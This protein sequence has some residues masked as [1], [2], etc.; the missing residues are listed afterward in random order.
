MWVL[1]TPGGPSR[2][3][4]ALASTKDRVARSL[5]LRGSRSGFLQIE[6]HALI[7]AGETVLLDQPFVDDST[8][9]RDLR[10]QHR[11]DQ[12]SDL[13]NHPLPRPA[14]G[15]PPRRRHR[16]LP[17]QVLSDRPTVQPGFPRNLR[18]AD[19][20]GLIQTAIPAKLQPPMWVQN[21]GQPPFA[22]PTD[23]AAD[24]PAPTP[25]TL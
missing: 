1:P 25:S 20:A 10:P 15:R 19:R 3:A 16:S 21:H 14:V 8:L 11:V 17:G 9:D 6:L 12:R 23:Q 22:A 4:F 13:V 5:T 2:A 24:C 7:V 18:Q